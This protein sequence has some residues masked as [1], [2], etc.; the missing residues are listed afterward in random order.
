VARGL[1]D[2]R[3]LAAMER[4]PRERFVPE[5]L[6][7]QAHGDHPLPIGAGQTI[8]Q[9]YIVALM[10]EAA[11]LGPDDRVLE[12]GTGSGYG[13]AVLAELAA[14]VWTIERHGEL[15]GSARA[16]LERLAYGNVH[17]LEGDGTL[18]HGDAAPYDAIVVTAGASEIPAPL[19]EQLADGGRLI[20]PVGEHSEAQ[21]LLRVRRNGEALLHEDLGGVRFV[22]LVG[23]Y[24]E[25][26]R[27]RWR[28]S[29]DG[30]VNTSALN[31]PAGATEDMSRARPPTSDTG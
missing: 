6:Q 21:R 11:E 15:V 20:M 18:G 3:V 16:T 26:E 30:R 9:P 7:R 24:G 1:H 12:I 29:P 13:A 22:P 8:S 10:A 17:V 5:A 4:V 2:E 23:R 28:A 31:P 25:A 14:E 19:L 27:G